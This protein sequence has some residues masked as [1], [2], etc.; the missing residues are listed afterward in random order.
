MW[1]WVKLIFSASVIIVWIVLTQIDMFS[2]MLIR[3]TINLSMVLPR[4]E[5]FKELNS[6]GYVELETK[7]PWNVDEI[8]YSKMHNKN[9]IKHALN[10][11]KANEDYY[12]NDRTDA[13]VIKTQQQLEAVIIRHSQYSREKY[14]RNIAMEKASRL[15]SSLRV[16]FKSAVYFDGINFVYDEKEFEAES[17]NS[18]VKKVLFDE[19]QNQRGSE[20]VSRPHGYSIFIDF[21]PY[22]SWVFEWFHTVGF[23][24]AG[25]VALLPYLSFDK[26]IKRIFGRK[27]EKSC[28]PR[29]ERYR[30]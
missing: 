1:K 2:D 12:F 20:I 15:L 24:I 7:T 9:T 3:H 14:L 29:R 5:R 8:L 6:I 11:I 28:Q 16:H 21:T 19:L 30:N 26:I 18:K 25:F 4:S 17:A 22:R 13:A 23:I 10:Y 27:Q